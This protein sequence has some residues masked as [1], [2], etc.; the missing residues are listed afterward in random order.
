MKKILKLFTILLFIVVF[1]TSPLSAKQSQVYTGDALV[2]NGGGIFLG[3]VVATDGTNSVTIDIYDNIES[4][5][6]R[7]IIPWVVTTSASNRS[8]ALGFSKED[9]VTFKSGIYVDVTTSGT[10]SYQVIYLPKG[11]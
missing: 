4:G 9:D 1:L 8:Q 7:L 11:Q 2:V 5:G 6:G 10:V 3:I